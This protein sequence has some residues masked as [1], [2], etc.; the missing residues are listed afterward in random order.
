[1]RLLDTNVLSELMR[2]EP[3]PR[4]KRWADRLPRNAFCTA[5]VVAAELRFGLELLPPDQRRRRTSVVIDGVL[6]DLLG[7]RILPFDVKSARRYAAFRAARQQAG[8]PASVQDAMIAGTAVAHRV[9]AVVTRNLDDFEG[10]GLP[11]IDPWSI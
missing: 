4:V 10:C 8:R 1:L 6:R 5:T 7:G 9:E 2:L 3:D 11:L